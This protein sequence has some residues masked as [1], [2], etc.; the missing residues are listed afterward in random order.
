MIFEQ[1]V[2]V[3][4]IA[5]IAII[6]IATIPG[7][8]VSL[9]YN[10]EIGGFFKFADQASDA[11]TKSDYFNQ[12]VEAIDKNKLTEGCNSIWFCEQPNARMEDKYKVLKSLQVRLNELKTLKETETAYQLGMTQ[13]TEN[14]FCWFPNNAFHQQYLLKHGIWWEALSPTGTYNDC[15]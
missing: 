13:M 6:I 11:Q 3:F 8:L 7:W 2:A 4:F 12:Y 15:E 10:E 14:E 1:G 9:K 5:L